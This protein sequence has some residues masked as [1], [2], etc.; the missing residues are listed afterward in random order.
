MK[1]SI[2]I[3]CN[4]DTCALSSC[5]REESDLSDFDIILDSTKRLKEPSLPSFGCS[6]LA[7]GDKQLEFKK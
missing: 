6:T 1:T 3:L 2:D 5:G 7:F 4:S